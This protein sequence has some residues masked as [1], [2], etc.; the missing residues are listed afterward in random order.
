MKEDL[1]HQN[2]S[3]KEELKEL[4]KLYE[5]ACAH[6]TA[7][8]VRD[9][10]DAAVG[11]Q[12]P[13]EEILFNEYKDK[14]EL[15]YEDKI[16]KCIPFDLPKSNSY[17]KGDKILD[18]VEV[19]VKVCNEYKWKKDTLERKV[20]ELV[21]EIRDMNDA[22]ED[23]KSENVDLENECS[24]LKEKVQK[25]VEELMLKEHKQDTKECDRFGTIG[26]SS[27]DTIP[28]QRED[29]EVQEQKI[30]SLES[31]IE[32]LREAR[33]NLEAD[34]AGLREENQQLKKEL[35]SYE[36]RLRNQENLE[37]EVTEWKDKYTSEHANLKEIVRQ[38]SVIEEECKALRLK[39]ENGCNGNDNLCKECGSSYNRKEH[40]S[41]DYKDVDQKENENGRGGEVKE[42]SKSVMSSSNYGN[43][44]CEDI[45]EQIQNL[46]TERHRILSV[47][48]EKT[49]ENSQLKTENHRLL[50][51]VAAEK[52]AMTKLQED[53]KTLLHQTET[54]ESSQIS[55]EAC[56]NLTKVIKDKDLEI[57]SLQQKTQSLLSLL[58]DSPTSVNIQN[59]LEE[60][61]AL[62]KAL[63]EVQNE[64]DELIRGLQVKHQEN[65]QY[66][67]EIQR[68]NALLS[69]EQQKSE[70][71][72][73][74]HVN[75]IQLYED[76]QKT[77]LNTQNELIFL[78]QKVDKMT[79]LQVELEKYKQVG[80][81]HI[82]ESMY[83]DLI[84]EKEYFE[85]K[86][87]ELETALKATEGMLTEKLA[88][89][90]NLQQEFESK[91]EMYKLAEK[92]ANELQSQLNDLTKDALTE[93]HNISDSTLE[94][95][96]GTFAFLFNTFTRKI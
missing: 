93:D 45:D 69:T 26:E 55:R 22:L 33:S 27:L 65:V 81:V 46:Q 62:L 7:N 87:K 70:T 18:I 83:V 51:I 59:V 34:S 52:A 29:F 60:K 21:K 6:V 64:R 72:Q 28:E 92:R 78:K 25:L 8:T 71:L 1:H 9:V 16:I 43:H 24:E 75:L 12:N 96:V 3:L 88:Y 86:V 94:S 58:E 90:H 47:L 38:K 5:E 79:E 77:L 57:E 95:Q 85:R 67:S 11:D 50:Q 66:H 2:E 35:Q 17:K 82:K 41:Y 13:Y 56:A 40:L 37:K 74:Q 31:E 42:L 39:L 76:K 91:Q 49:R 30:F 19:I 14:L 23:A 20:S 89:I 84:E 73:Q 53:N 80:I 44:C 54:V 63:Q 15:E 68:L 61:D 48:D 4:R 32:A 36:A 10:V